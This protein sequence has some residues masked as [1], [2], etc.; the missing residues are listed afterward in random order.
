MKHSKRSSGN[1]LFSPGYG[2]RGPLEYEGDHD[3]HFC[4]TEP[5]P[6]WTGFDRPKEHRVFDNLKVYKAGKG[7]KASLRKSYV[8]IPTEV[9][10]PT[11][12]TIRANSPNAA[13]IEAGFSIRTV[14]RKVLIAKGEL[15]FASGV[16]MRLL[17][18]VAS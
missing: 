15:E 13:A 6:D 16:R 17:E 4:I 9:I 3:F 2:I 14:D 7:T 11:G 12:Q 18:G 1:S 10:M 8:E 5:D